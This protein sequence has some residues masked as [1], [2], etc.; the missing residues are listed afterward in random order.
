MYL[1]SYDVTQ[2]RRQGY[3]NKVLN[4]KVLM[5]MSDSSR[6]ELMIS[7]AHVPVCPPTANS[8]YHIYN[9]L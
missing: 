9:L 1:D 7:T 3:V 8:R 5:V 4:L 6:S 2:D